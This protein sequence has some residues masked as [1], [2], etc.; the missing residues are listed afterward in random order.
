MHISNHHTNMRNFV[1]LVSEGQKEP[2]YTK[3]F[4]SNVAVKKKR[5]AFRG[6]AWRSLDV[7][8]G[9]WF[10]TVH[11][12]ALFAPFTFTWGLFWTTFFGCVLG[13]MLGI[14]VTFHRNLAHRSFK[15]PKWLEYTFAYL[16][17]QAAQYQARNN[18]EDL[19]SQA[20]YRFIKRTYVWHILGFAVIVYAL[21]GF[22]CLV[23]VMGVRLVWGYHATFF[24]NSACHIWG[25]R[26]V[27]MISYG[28]GWHNNHHA[29]EFSARF[30]L[31]WWQLDMGWCTIRLLEALGLATNV[32]LPTETHKLKKSLASTNYDPIRYKN[33]SRGK[34][35]C[36]PTCS[37][38]A[39]VPHNCFRGRKAPTCEKIFMSDVVVT[40]KRSVFRGGA[41]RSLDVKMGVWFLTVHLLVLFAPFTFTWGVFWVAFLGYTLCIML[42]ITITYH[43][44]LAHLLPKWLEYT[45][46]Y[47]GVQAGQRDPIYW[48]SIHR[49]HHQYTESNKDPHSPI[50]GFWFS[51]MGW[52]FD[53]GLVIENYQ[54]RNNV[55]DLKSQAF[56]R[57]IKRT[58]VWH[59]L[60][61]AVIVYA[62]GGFPYLVWVVGVRLVWSY[63]ITFLVN[64]AC[65]IWGNRSWNTMD[66][67]KN[68]WWVA[69]NGGKLTLVGV[70]YGF[71]KHWDCTNV[72]LPTK[73]HKLKKS[74][75]LAN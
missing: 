2:V 54:A 4:M 49:Y 42:G 74:L 61:F 15:L 43:R 73:T 31:E 25:N 19:K 3:I 20:F 32:K 50:N 27:A 38:C 70:L 8:M 6:G 55:E 40:R 59:V 69:M 39:L 21:G 23:W 47:L 60:G 48:V 56:Y 53:S 30:G 51:H 66:L 5:S 1:R 52:L 64:S 16:G 14:S 46:A 26:W 12:L 68:N 65:H 33:K 45:F 34:L 41:W 37:A 67:S 13:L 71:L 44:N 9:V 29:F 72:K 57:F 36:G 22:P 17:V 35:G 24:V 10:L 18:V 62:L 7:K 75:A 11:L 63:H 28:E 58:Y